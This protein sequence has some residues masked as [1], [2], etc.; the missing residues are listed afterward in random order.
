MNSRAD[1]ILEKLGHS[2]RSPYATPHPQHHMGGSQ[3]KPGSPMNPRP[4][5]PTRPDGWRPGKPTPK[6]PKKLWGKQLTEQVRD[7]MK[8]RLEKKGST[9][10]SKA[11]YIIEKQA[12]LGNLI[13]KG[14]KKAVELARKAAKKVKEK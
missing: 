7:E 4:T 13:V 10:E 14:G 3:W 9:Y 12:G 11:D 8:S 2:I 1:Y 6:I 5:K